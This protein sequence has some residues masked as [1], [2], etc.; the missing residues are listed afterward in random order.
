MQGGRGNPRGCVSCVRV[1]R[2]LLF[3]ATTV[4]RDYR[5]GFKGTFARAVNHLGGRRL[6]GWFLRS[7]L[8]AI[9]RTSA[10]SST[11]NPRRPTP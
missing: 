4:V 8:A 10:D 6:F 11:I 2:E 3:G 1:G 9:E 5:N 7:A